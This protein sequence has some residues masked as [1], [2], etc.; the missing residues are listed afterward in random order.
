[1]KGVT[2]MRRILMLLTV[3]TVTLVVAGGVA[4]AVT[5]IG[6]N[7]PDTLW[8]TNGNDNLIGR[9]GND[10]LFALNGRDNLSGGPGKD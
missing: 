6:T 8:G 9:G 5:K 7:G 3:M 4:W 10:R 2:S 1:M